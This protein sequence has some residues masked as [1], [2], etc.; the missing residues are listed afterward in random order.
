MT[1]E[2][3]KK[4]LVQRF[5]QPLPEFY[6]RR[7]IFGN[8]ETK[9]F[10]NEINELSLS[11]VKVLILSETNQTVEKVGLAKALSKSKNECLKSHIETHLIGLTQIDFSVI[12]LF[13]VAGT[14]V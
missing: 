7:I 3:I 12:K 14:E 10:I 5:E 1:L 2:D 9:E 6:K 8:D 4:E 13:I 11:N